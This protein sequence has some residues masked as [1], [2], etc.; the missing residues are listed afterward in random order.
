MKEKESQAT[1]VGKKWFKWFKKQN[2]SIVFKKPE[3]V[4]PKR[5]DIAIPTIRTYFEQLRYLHLEHNISP[6]R[7]FNVN[8]TGLLLSPDLAKS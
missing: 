5:M 6:S 2:P 3:K 8:E 1:K 7:I 4:D